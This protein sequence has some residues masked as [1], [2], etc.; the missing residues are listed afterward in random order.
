MKKKMLASN[1]QVRRATVD[2]L[3]VL[4]RLWEQAQMPSAQL[5]KRVTE[6]QVAESAIGE[7]LGSVGLQVIGT[8]GQI[9]SEVYRAPE[10]AFELQPRLW[11]RILILARNLGLHRLWVRGGLFWTD[12]GFEA[13]SSEELK[14]LP[15][16][17]DEVEGTSWLTF[18]LRD[19]NPA[20]IS[21]EQEWN[22]F[23]QS[24]QAE[25]Q[26]LMHSA[27][28]LRMLATILTVVAL[29]LVACAIGYILLR[30]RPPH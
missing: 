14:T 7:L 28:V 2:D 15:A 1:I 3:A 13:P 30:Q 17:F 26:R 21:V 19:E 12:Q 9:H 11:D 27:Q 8:H 22:L 5:E 10:L 4:R 18:K 23:R 16:A 6:F 25:N 20:A 29:I 24:Q